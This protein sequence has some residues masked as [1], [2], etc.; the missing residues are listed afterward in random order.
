ML[1]ARGRI[2]VRCCLLMPADQC[3]PGHGQSVPEST[4]LQRPHCYLLHFLHFH[5]ATAVS[6]FL[7]LK[8]PSFPADRSVTN[9]GTC[10][11]YSH[12]PACL[13]ALLGCVPGIPH[14]LPTVVSRRQ[15]DCPGSG[16][17]EAP[18]GREVC[19]TLRVCEE[20]DKLRRQINFLSVA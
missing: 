19:Q 9:T 5:A 10:W 1:P 16:V 15:Q 8:E 6:Q 11:L 7:S 20:P 2:S 17:G 18:S 3:I 12:L 4:D 14:P 13:P